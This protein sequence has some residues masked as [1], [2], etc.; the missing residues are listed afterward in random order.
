MLT[1]N[2]Y[3]NDVNQGGWIMG[4]RKLHKIELE[5][6]DFKEKGLRIRVVKLF[7]DEEDYTCLKIEQLKEILRLWIIGEEERY[8][9]SEGNRGRWMIFDEIKKVFDEVEVK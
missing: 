9:Q 5:K 6:D 8:P 2:L 4:Y 3:Y 7:Y 1:S